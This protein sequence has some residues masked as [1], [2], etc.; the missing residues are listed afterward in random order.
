[1]KSYKDKVVFITGGAHGIGLSL[2][3]MYHRK[4]AKV[5]VVDINEEN[6]AKLEQDLPGLLGR[7]CDIT[8]REAVYE[9]A[10]EVREQVGDPALVINNAGV[11]ENSDFLNCSDE[12][13]ERTMNVNI[14]SHFW[15]LKAFLPS[16]LEKGEG[17]VCEIASAA[18]LMGGPG[19]VAYCASKHAVIGF[20]R[21]LK[22]EVDR[23][24]GGKVKFTIVCPSFISTGMFEGV[25]PAR[26]TPMLGQEEIAKIIFDSIDREKTMVLEPFM[27][28]LLPSLIAMLPT[29]VFEFVS[30]IFGV[31]QAMVDINTREGQGRE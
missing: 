12:S 15:V 31:D 16:M 13:L 19:M 21:A 4:S 30:K 22:Q 26:L 29:S 28:K 5:V 23:L 14:V 7:V 17:H 25:K 9:M 2:A 6:L 1:M 8:N 3:R 10:R 27:V 20:G 18:G 24:S 11:V